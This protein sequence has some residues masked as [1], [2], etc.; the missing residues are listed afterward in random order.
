MTAKRYDRAYYDHWYRGQGFGSPLRLDRKVAYA[1]AAAEY[2]L[3]RPVCSVLDVGCGEGAWQP[4]LRRARPQATY[5]GVDPSEYAIERYGSRRGLRLGDLGSLHELA[6]GGPFDLIVCVDVVA[7][8]PAEPLRR[9]LRTMSDLAGG[10]ALIELFAQG[11]RFEGDEDGF[12]HRPPATYD[13][14]FAEAGLAQVG[15]SLFVPDALQA[16]LPS[17]HG[18]RPR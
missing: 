12:H 17:F 6:L 14:W 11:D 3:E 7:Y 2:L 15:P 16:L 13:R 9:G 1:L 8:V 4:A 10:V 5:L 18:G